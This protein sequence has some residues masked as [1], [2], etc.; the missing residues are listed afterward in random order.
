MTARSD[1]GTWLSSRRFHAIHC[2]AA[3]RSNG[4][5]IA[6]DQLGRL[7]WL[8]VVDDTGRYHAHWLQ[9]VDVIQDV[10]VREMGGEK[11]QGPTAQA[12]P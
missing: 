9:V 2:L 3:L 8:Q 4:R 12:R 6:G 10:I 1:C 7:H 11:G 5:L